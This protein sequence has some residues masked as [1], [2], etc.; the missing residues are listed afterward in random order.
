MAAAR[1]PA[2][3]GDGKRA[4]GATR[5]F[6]PA[7]VAARPARSRA[8]V[9]PVAIPRDVDEPSYAFSWNPDKQAVPA[10]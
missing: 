1:R 10:G 9:S 2:R 5:D 6:H 3:R 7:T 4:K 8:S